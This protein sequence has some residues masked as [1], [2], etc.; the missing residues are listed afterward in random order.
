MKNLFI[1]NKRDIKNLLRFGVLRTEVMEGHGLYG[2]KLGMVILFYEYSR[3]SG[4]DLYEQFAIEM[5]ESLL[6]IPENLPLTFSNGLSGIGWGI[7]YLLRENFVEGDIDDILSEVDERLMNADD[8]R[9]E[10]VKSLLTYVCF[11]EAYMKQLGQERLCE[12]WRAPFMEK[13]YK[14]NDYSTYK[15]DE[16]K[17]LIW[18]NW[19]V[20]KTIEL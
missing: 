20:L 15:E 10:D 4:D 14:G 1:R 9:A 6:N 16:I 11:R 12:A 8:L 17:D 13:F 18:R 3:Y 2:G 5:I 19:D 7:T